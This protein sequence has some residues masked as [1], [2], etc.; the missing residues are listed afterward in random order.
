MSLNLLLPSYCPNLYFVSRV[1][2]RIE[3]SSMWLV[4]DI[5][6]NQLWKHSAP[7]VVFFR[8]LVLS[9][10]SSQFVSSSCFWLNSNAAPGLWFVILL[11]HLLWKHC[12]L[13][14]NLIYILSGLSRF[15][16]IS[17]CTWCTVD[18]LLF[19]FHHSD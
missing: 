18:M 19:A 4:K 17:P 10:W 7:T 5:E 12:W 13:W 9:F 14:L 11:S 3:A 6:M 2:S 16:W 1:V 15:S 8:L